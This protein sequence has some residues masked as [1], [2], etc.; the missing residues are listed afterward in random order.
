MEAQLLRMGQVVE[1]VT[2]EGVT[3]AAIVA[4]VTDRP[5]GIVNL[6]VFAK[7]GTPYIIQ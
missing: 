1:Y 7:D 2:V 3:C 4:S 5:G 6:C